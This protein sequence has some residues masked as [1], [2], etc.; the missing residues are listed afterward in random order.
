MALSEVQQRPLTVA[1]VLG[2]VVGL[3][4]PLLAYWAVT[5]GLPSRENAIAW[6]WV[7]A[8]V[9]VLSLLGGTAVA[10]FVPSLLL[11]SRDRSASAVHAWIGAREVRR[12]FG[13]A[14][15]AMNIPTTPEEA[16]Q[17]LAKQPDTPRLRPL[18]FEMLLLTRRYDEARTAARN[19]PG[20]TALD[21]YRRAEGIAMAE[22][23]QTGR[24]DMTDARLALARIPSGIDRSE[25]T[26]S[27]AVFEARRLVGRG[28][29]RA[30][31]LDAR[32][33]IPGS[34]LSIL[35]RDMSWPIFRYLAPRV[36]LPVA[37]L[38]VVVSLL[39]TL[40]ERT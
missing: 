6:L 10:A 3:A 24:A 19:F 20:D 27:L 18:R 33:L 30:P 14:T 23:Q 4:G 5:S 29:W 37:A 25:A 22:D 17:W 35:A 32:P 7:A 13:S 26:A 21:E 36:V 1:L 15:A 16:E 8:V 28:D 2:F 12:M 31:L 11:D 38:I 9:S 40:A 39:V 34:D